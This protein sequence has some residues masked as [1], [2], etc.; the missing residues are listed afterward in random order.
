MNYLQCQDLS[1][2]D[3]KILHVVCEFKN[4]YEYC[5]RVQ[6][7]QENHTILFLFP[8]QN[9]CSSEILAV[10]T[11]NKPC[12]LCH[13]VQEY[14]SNCLQILKDKILL[15]EKPDFSIFKLSGILTR[16]KGFIHIQV[17]IVLNWSDIA[18]QFFFKNP[19]FLST[20]IGF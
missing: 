11:L 15:K 9:L 1:S 13:P 19:R 17:Q 7:V 10:S 2:C 16:N 6:Y 5:H 4:L 3:K 20:I 14:E 8:L 12:R 18:V